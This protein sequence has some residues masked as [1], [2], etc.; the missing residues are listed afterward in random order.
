MLVCVFIEKIS[1][2]TYIQY[3][4]MWQTQMLKRSLKTKTNN[5][6]CDWATH[7]W[8]ALICHAINIFRRLIQLH[9]A[10]NFI[11]I[12]TTQW[13]NDIL[14]IITKTWQHSTQYSDHFG[15]GNKK[16]K[17]IFFLFVILFTTFQKNKTNAF[18]FN[19]RFA[20]LNN[21]SVSILKRLLI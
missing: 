14:H 16:K 6:F 13:T 3:N 5:L 21:V 12:Y 17:Q 9:F 20:I 1:C 10:L 15:F 8:N 11:I 2:N 18:N 7:R 19:F 4:H